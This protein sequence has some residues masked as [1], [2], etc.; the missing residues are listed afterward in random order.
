MVVLRL[1]TLLELE[2]DRLIIELF[3][4]IFL[5]KICVQ[6]RDLYF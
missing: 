3:F 5:N 1:R 4:G 2:L 6:H